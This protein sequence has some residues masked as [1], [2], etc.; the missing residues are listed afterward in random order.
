ML[1][2]QDGEAGRPQRS[3]GEARLGSTSEGKRERELLSQKLQT[4]SKVCRRRIMA[5]DLNRGWDFSVF[6]LSTLQACCRHLTPFFR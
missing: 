5:L 1:G 6:A 2:E 4:V 3:A